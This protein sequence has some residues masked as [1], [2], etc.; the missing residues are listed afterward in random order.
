M[1][2]VLLVC[3][4]AVALAPATTCAAAQVDASPDACATLVDWMTGSFSSHAQSVADTNYFDIRLEMV[5]IWP[6][7]DDGVWMT[8]PTAYVFSA[9]LSRPFL[10]SL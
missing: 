4:C 6:E 9:R 8:G 5:R 7:R 10:D 1:K 2:S 3:L